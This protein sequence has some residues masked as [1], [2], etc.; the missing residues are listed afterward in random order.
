MGY[1]FSK[2]QSWELIL[3]YPHNLHCLCSNDVVQRVLQSINPSSNHLNLK[4][5]EH[6]NRS[7][8]VWR[9]TR[10]FPHG[11]S[12]TASL[13][14]KWHQKSEVT[15]D[16]L[17]I[18]PL[19]K[20]QGYLCKPDSHSVAF[21]ESFLGGRKA[22]LLCVPESETSQWISF[23]THDTGRKIFRDLLAFYSYTMT[24]NI[25]PVWDSISG[26]EMET[27]KDEAETDWHDLCPHWANSLVRKVKNIKLF[28]TFLL[29]F[30][31][32]FLKKKFVIKKPLTYDLLS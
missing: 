22:L 21:S 20:S 13:P 17:L 3:C 27:A 1:K 2:Q 4:V 7:V 8:K 18:K 31:L 25:S 16:F 26:Y 6:Q 14:V 23:L 15:C 11:F 10:G 5:P 24:Q 9:P 30:W 29:F 28:F 19:G 32:E 12:I